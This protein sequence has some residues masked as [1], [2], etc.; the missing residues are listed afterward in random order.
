MKW[1]TRD[2]ELTTFATETLVTHHTCRLHGR[3]FEIQTHES[4]FFLFVCFPFP[5]DVATSRDD[6][7]R[8]CL[9]LYFVTK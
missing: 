9:Y 1:N 6:E 7:R 3:H 2:E 4:W 5:R 8:L